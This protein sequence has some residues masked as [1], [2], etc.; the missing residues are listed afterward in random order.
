MRKLR[1]YEE[2]GITEGVIWKQLLIFF[3]P[4]ILGTFFQQ[5][6]NTVD[7]VIVGQF[8][9][10]QALAAVGGPTGVLINLLVGFFVGLSSG[11]TV[12]ISQYYGAQQNEEVSRAVHTAIALAVAAGAVITMVGLLFAPWALAAIDTPAD[13]MEGSI[14]YLRIYFVGMI[15]S[16][17]YNMGAGILRAAGDSRRPLYFLICGCLVNIVLDLLFVLV[18][19]MEV[20]G[21]AI[22]TILSQA[23]SAV[24]VVVALLR[25]N[26]SY[27]LF[28]KKIRFYWDMLRRIVTIGLPAGLQS[29]MYSFSVILIQSHVNT[30]G[31]DTVAAWTAYGKIDAI[32]WMTMDAF[33]VSITTFVGQNFGARKY[34]R[35]HKSVKVCLAMAMGVTVVMSVL[36]FF[37]SQYIYRIFTQDGEVI[38]KGIEI[39]QLLVP[40]WF[41]YV[42]IAILSGAVRGTGDAVI[43][44]IMTCV[45]VCVLRILWLFTAVP[46]HR[47][48]QMVLVSF[49]ITWTVT[50]IIFIIYYLQGGWLRRRRAIAGD[51]ELR[52]PR[53]SKGGRSSAS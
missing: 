2:N 24:L 46:L 30:F 38:A 34:D 12:I 22:A 23:V 16:L 35:I 50:S 5:L 31:T 20:E 27:R 13:I 15:P 40:F 29:V 26:Q 19:K 6:Y 18:F 47:T 45:G 21:A 1:T 3:F 37:F 49:P 44:M 48:L 14:A 39:L 33:G 32:F 7:A 28:W 41:T 43:P 11:A 52:S 8:V 36:L 51:P 10:K 53:R 25:T 9:G 42:T 4:I 17:V